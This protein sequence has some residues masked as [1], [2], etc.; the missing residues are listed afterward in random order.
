MRMMTLVAIAALTVGVAACAGAET[1]SAAPAERAM[2]S[3]KR[4]A[5]PDLRKKVIEVVSHEWMDG[6]VLRPFAG[7]A[8]QYASRR[9]MQLYL[10]IGP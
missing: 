4:E 10:E 7:Q 6:Q 8:R 5:T 2:A 9:T 3:A 1:V